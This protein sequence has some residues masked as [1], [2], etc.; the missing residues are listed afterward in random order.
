MSMR[1]AHTLVERIPLVN[2][3]VLIFLG[4]LKIYV[5]RLAYR[6]PFVFLFSLLGVRTSFPFVSLLLMLGL[7][8]LCLLSSC[9][10]CLL[11]LINTRWY[12]F[13]LHHIFYIL[14]SVPSWN[15]TFKWAANAGRL[16][17]LLFGLQVSIL[18]VINIFNC[19]L[20]SLCCQISPGLLFF[21]LRQFFRML[22]CYRGYPFRYWIDQRLKLKHWLFPWFLGI[23]GWML[24][25][26][27]LIWIRL[28]VIWVLILTIN[29]YCSW[30]FP[31]LP[32]ISQQFCIDVPKYVVSI[33]SW[34]IGDVD[35]VCLTPPM[36]QTIGIGSDLLAFVAKF[37]F[38][39][40]FNHFMSK[41]L[42]LGIR[43]VLNTLRRRHEGQTI[44]IINQF[45]TFSHFTEFMLLALFLN[46][47]KNSGQKVKNCLI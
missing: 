34:H 42:Y 40:I 27:L 19:D 6:H 38:S 41:F 29:D 11:H 37:M 39:A 1:S 24:F 44:F 35:T 15:F 7:P 20:L 8:K 5:F 2:F 10:P 26:F 28:G 46:I 23:S 14:T 25:L 4:L 12:L 21:L 47:Q 13:S 31:F 17:F 36:V 16:S 30:V 33:K 32:I 22:V 45:T 9:F 18:L 3:Y 43:L